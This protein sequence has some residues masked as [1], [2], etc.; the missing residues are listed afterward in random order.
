MNHNMSVFRIFANVEN[1]STKR[2]WNGSIELDVQNVVS[3]AG[4]QFKW[5]ID[6]KLTLK[7][8]GAIVNGFQTT[9]G[10]FVGGVWRPTPGVTVKAS[11]GFDRAAAYGVEFR[12][13]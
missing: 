9:K 5:P 12:I 13:T 8:G 3:G 6:Q 4:L 11:T 2:G 7:W 1:R 10:L